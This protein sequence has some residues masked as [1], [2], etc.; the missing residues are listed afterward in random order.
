M[1]VKGGVR[2]LHQSVVSSLVI[3]AERCYPECQI[4]FKLAFL[5]H[6]KTFIYLSETLYASTQL[7]A[8]QTP[9]PWGL[10]TF[11]NGYRSLDCVLNSTASTEYML[12]YSMS[13]TRRNFIVA[14]VGINR[15]LQWPSAMWML[16]QS[17]C[18]TLLAV[19]FRA[20]KQKIHS[21]S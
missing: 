21:N 5:I 18:K 3:V 7:S 15:S 2:V 17:T 12:T 13:N 8:R 16:A 1:L 20:H 10:R 19:R 6:Y 4:I 14:L 9:C 11:T